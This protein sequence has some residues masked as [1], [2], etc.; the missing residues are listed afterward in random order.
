MQ[1]HKKRE[2]L[3]KITRRFVLFVDLPYTRLDNSE[4]PA[5]TPNPR[6]RYRQDR[7]RWMKWKMENAFV[8]ALEGSC[9]FDTLFPARDINR[10]N[11]APQF[12]RPTG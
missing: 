12:Y 11:I 9:S 1:I 3:T 5:A 8:A 4:G 6:S 10:F 7:E 2:A